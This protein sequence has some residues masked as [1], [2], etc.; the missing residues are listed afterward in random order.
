MAQCRVDNPG[1]PST[2][3]T[4]VRPFNQIRY[5]IGQLPVG[6]AAQLGTCALWHRTWA[7]TVAARRQSWQIQR[8]KGDGSGGD[9]G[10]WVLCMVALESDKDGGGLTCRVPVM[11]PSWT[12]AQSACDDIA[13]LNPFPAL[14]PSSLGSRDG[15]VETV[16]RSLDGTEGTA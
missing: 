1:S 10:G 14:S 12:D 3:M 6:W 11:L 7:A 16:W 8:Q 4:L 13:L 15:R 5:L 2:L 9:G